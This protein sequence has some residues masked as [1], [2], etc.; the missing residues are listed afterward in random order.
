MKEQ[1]TSRGNPGLFPVSTIVNAQMAVQDTIC[2]KTCKYQLFVYSERW[3]CV[4]DCRLTQNEQFFSYI[5][6]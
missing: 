5:M 3:Y 2:A 4:S 6:A 1:L